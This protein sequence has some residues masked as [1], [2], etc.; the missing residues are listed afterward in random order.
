MFGGSKP[1]VHFWIEG[2]IENDEII[3]NL[4]QW[5]SRRCLLNISL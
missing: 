5:L 3:C 2:I 4:D 1:F